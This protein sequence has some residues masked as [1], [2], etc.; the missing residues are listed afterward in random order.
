MEIS[1]V[2]ANEL[3]QQVIREKIV[4]GGLFVFSIIGV[5]T[6]FLIF[7]QIKMTNPQ[8]NLLIDIVLIFTIY[9]ATFFRKHLTVAQRAWIIIIVSYIAGASTLATLANGD[10]GWAF[11][12]LATVLSAVLLDTVF[13]IF[14][15]AVCSIT[16]LLFGWGY[17]S[18]SLSLAV[19]LNSY[20]LQWDTWFKALIDYI[21]ISTCTVSAFYFLNK[22]LLQSFFE[23]KKHNRVLENRVRKRTKEL[24]KEK[25]KAEELARTDFL[26]GLNNRRA[27]FEFAELINEEAKR[28]ENEYSIVMIDLDYF[29]QINDTF[30]HKIGDIALQRAANCIKEIS[31][32]CD[33]S[34]RVGGEEFV[35]LFPQTNLEQVQVFVKRLQDQINSTSIN[36][37]DKEL[38]FTASYG[39]ASSS[40]NIKSIETILSHADSALYRAKNSGRNQIVIY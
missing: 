30:G 1:K 5:P 21:I 32:A 3:N 12:C 29:K 35:I 40:E 22:A 9:M 24:E 13:T 7:S 17:T 26:T 10:A 15:F 34:A 27:F 2:T 38:C 36:I 8:S 16:I 6:L 25:Q 28:Y 23:L 39:V 14:I 37:E 18:N 20:N 19:D 4:D 31:R 33:V 11:L